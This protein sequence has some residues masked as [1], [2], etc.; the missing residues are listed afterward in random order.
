MWPFLFE[1]VLYL[2]IFYRSMMSIPDPTAVST[3]NQEAAPG[4]LQRRLSPID[5]WVC[6]HAEL[7]FRETRERAIRGLAVPPVD[8][9]DPKPSTN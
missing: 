6:C 1:V 4:D 2:P 7:R 3:S 8:L 9:E 5:K